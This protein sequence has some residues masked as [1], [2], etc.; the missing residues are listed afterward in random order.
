METR[1]SLHVLIA[2][3]VLRRSGRQRHAVQLGAE[4][5]PAQEGRRRVG[6]RVRVR[7]PAAPRRRRAGVRV[8][9]RRPAA[10]SPTARPAR[11]TTGGALVAMGVAGA[12]YTAMQ[13]LRIVTVGVSG[14]W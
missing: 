12:S 5:R 9:V 4:R 10:P 13:K 11:A 7:R 6:V 3:G 8:R 2:A 1:S 14:G